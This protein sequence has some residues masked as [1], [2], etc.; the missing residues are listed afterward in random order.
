MTYPNDEP[1][2]EEIRAA[3]YLVAL[4][5]VT[6]VVLGM[7]LF[8]GYELA[9]R[10]DGVVGRVCSPE[11]EAEACEE[12]EVC[13][14][15]QCL[16][17]PE[18]LPALPCQEGDACGECACAAPLACDAAD[19]CVPRE[20]PRCSAEVQTLLG[21][22][23]RFERE[24]CRSAGADASTCPPKD[25]QD[26]FVAHADFNR[27]LLGLEHATTIHFDRR[28]PGADG[29]PPRQATH[30]RGE[31]AALAD[32]VRTAEHVLIVGRA[33]EDRGQDASTRT[34]NNFLAQA[35]MGEVR[36]W[37]VGLESTPEGR[38]ALGAKFLT[39]AIGTSH[40]LDVAAL[41]R[42]PFHRYVAWSARATAELR[43]W[44]AEHARLDVATT[45]QM[46]R[47]LNQSVLVIPIPCEIP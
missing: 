19:R 10:G 18:P 6:T 30:Y 21:D 11:T 44:V 25:L 36:E 4:G 45:E 40:P 9:A 24:R 46:V 47:R 33:S 5:G 37:L 38:D 7:V 22:L 2:A 32:R 12:D 41:A 15:G 3:H 31:M 34:R 8:A 20:A 16:A 27:L 42:N 39:L 28:Q 26:F 23:R 14:G 17:A 1:T 35:R 29:L 13:R 43:G